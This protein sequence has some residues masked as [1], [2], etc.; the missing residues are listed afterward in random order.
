M[1]LKKYLQELY[2]WTIKND[3][4]TIAYEFRTVKNDSLQLIFVG[5]IIL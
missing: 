5:Q 1:K 3:L 2:Y 4:R